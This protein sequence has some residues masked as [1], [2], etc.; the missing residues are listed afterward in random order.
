M[1]II[2][3]IKTSNIRNEIILFY[4]FV[5]DGH[6]LILFMMLSDKQPVTLLTNMHEKTWLIRYENIANI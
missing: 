2:I 3:H 5:R 4:I 6:G 1:W